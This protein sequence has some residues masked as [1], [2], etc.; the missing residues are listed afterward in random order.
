MSGRQSPIQPGAASTSSGVVVSTPLPSSAARS[1]SN[2]TLD[3]VLDRLNDWGDRMDTLDEHMAGFRRSLQRIDER[4][5]TVVGRVDAVER[6]ATEDA[7]ESTGAPAVEEDPANTTP[8][9]P[10]LTTASGKARA[11]S[12]PPSPHSSRHA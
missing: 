8:Q 5:D 6:W 4:M 3:M 11:R 9:P 10:V 7:T 2:P 1:P 12:P